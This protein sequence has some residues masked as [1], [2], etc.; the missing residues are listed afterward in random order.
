MNHHTVTYRAYKV[1][2]HFARQIPLF[3]TLILRSLTLLFTALVHRTHSSCSMAGESDQTLL[4]ADDAVVDTKTISG[5]ESVVVV[6][7]SSSNAVIEKMARK[8]V[9]V[10]TDY[11]KKSKVTEADR[12]ADHTTDWLSGGVES[13]VPDLELLT[14]DNTTVV[15]FDS[16]LSAGLDLPPS[17]FLVSILN[18][19]RC[20]L[21]HLNPN[22]IAALSYFTMLCKC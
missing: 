13:F 10:L 5:A 9:H 14:V 4:A 16:H 11:S 20:E 3:L 22:A 18:F 2:H 12:A 15:C 19:L 6:A 21:V 7:S 8:D 1:G 17:K